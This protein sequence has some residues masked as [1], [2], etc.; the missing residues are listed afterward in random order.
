MT[1]LEAILSS[2]IA[3]IGAG[4]VGSTVA[5]TLINKPIAS[6]I[7]LVDPK[8]EIRDAHVRDLSDATFHGSTSTTIRAG[9]HKEAGQCDIIIVTAGAKQKKGES[10]TDLIDR[11]RHILRSVINDM[12]PLKKSAIL[13]LVANPVDILTYFA[14]EFSGLP[15][16]HVI[17]SG[18]YLDSARL[19][20]AIAAKAGVAAS[21]I[22]AYVLGE[23]GE[24]QVVA[25]SCSNVSG[26]PLSQFPATQ[27][28]DR[29]AM[30]AETKDKAAAI[31]SSKGSTEFG[32]A[33]VA[34]SIC[35]SILFNH[36]NVKPV[37]HYQDEYN[38][39]LSKPAIL[40]RNG[41]EG[42]VELPL[43]EEEKAALAH[44]YSTLEHR[45]PETMSEDAR[46][47]KQECEALGVED[48]EDDAWCEWRVGFQ[49]VER[50]ATIISFEDHFTIKLYNQDFVAAHT[51][52]DGVLQLIPAFEEW[53]ADVISDA[54][55]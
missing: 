44:S 51:S 50:L 41:I 23:H 22:D 52:T 27:N 53:S 54:S 32:I 55:V 45:D 24:S 26:V 48:A 30:A 8:E 49:D 4:S 35:K 6:E 38:V 47:R 17:G 31:I 40:S 28:L 36:R 7:L 20:G 37:S 16:Q 34:A 21:S 13:L 39:C 12:K 29:A 33:S 11:N 15:K 46:K 42:T 10:R 2:S 19:R 25:W 18:T 5:Y 9:T 3:V 1:S 43:N 14:L